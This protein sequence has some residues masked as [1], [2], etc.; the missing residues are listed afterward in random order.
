M[1]ETK[2]LDDGFCPHCHHDVASDDELHVCVKCGGPCCDDC[3]YE[4][5]KR[6]VCDKCLIVWAV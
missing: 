3:G 6:W 5:D 4:A 1:G 2:R